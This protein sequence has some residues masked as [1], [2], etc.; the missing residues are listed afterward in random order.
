ME[1]LSSQEQEFREG[2]EIFPEWEVDGLPASE[3]PSWIVLMSSGNFDKTAMQKQFPW[4]GAHAWAVRREDLEDF[5]TVY[6]D[7]QFSEYK[8][9]PNDKLYSV[10]YEEA[11]RYVT[12]KTQK[13]P[14]LGTFD[15]EH[16]VL[17][18]TIKRPSPG[19]FGSNDDILLPYPHFDNPHQVL[20][21]R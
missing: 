12:G 13:M 17:V 16:H 11:D 7:G 20:I 3:L 5:L 19:M 9:D 15:P 18:K 1:G 10:N 21:R 14:T 4:K 6:E 2:Y 8:P